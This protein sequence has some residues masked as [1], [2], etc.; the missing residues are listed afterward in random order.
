[1]YGWTHF[2][3]LRV[4]LRPMLVVDDNTHPTKINRGFI[5]NKHDIGTLNVITRMLDHGYIEIDTC[6]TSADNIL[7]TNLT[8]LFI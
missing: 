1:M 5:Y 7:F 2:T 3:L 6:I 8:K 4:K